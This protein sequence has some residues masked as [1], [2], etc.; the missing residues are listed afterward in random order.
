MRA[1]RYLWCALFCLNVVQGSEAQAQTSNRGDA[2]YL[3]GATFLIHSDPSGATRALYQA[4]IPALKRA[5]S[6]RTEL[7]RVLSELDELGQA[8]RGIKTP[9]DLRQL[10]DHPLAKKYNLNRFV[11]TWDPLQQRVLLRSAERDIEAQITR[12]EDGLSALRTSF[13]DHTLRP[14]I[15]KLNSKLLGLADSASIDAVLGH[16]ALAK[17][18]EFKRVAQRIRSDEPIEEIIRT[19]AKRV[20]ERGLEEVG[21]LRGRIEEGRKK[22]SNLSDLVNARRQLGNISLNLPHMGSSLNGASQSLSTL[23][24]LY[25]NGD[26]IRLA[27]QV[28]ETTAS[29]GRLQQAGQMLLA[30]GTGVGAFM[31]VSSVM[32]GLGG[33]G[34]SP[35]DNNAAVLAQLEKLFDY[36]QKQFEIVNAKLDRIIE[37][38][39]RI[40]GKVDRILGAIASLADDVRGI[41]RKIEILIAR[42]DAG[43]ARIA[44]TIW[45]G[46]VSGCIG[47]VENNAIKSPAQFS[48]CLGKFVALAEAAL[49]PPFVINTRTHPNWEEHLAAV[50]Q[51]NISDATELSRYA[52][53]INELASSMLGEKPIALQTANHA[54]LWKASH[55]IARLTQ[56][57][58]EY[59]N[60]S[61]VLRDQLLAIASSARTTEAQLTELVG[62][63][64]DDHRQRAIKLSAEG[65]QK[66]LGELKTDLSLMRDL[67]AETYVNDL[68]AV[69]KNE[70]ADQ[71]RPW[72]A[73]VSKYDPVLRD[74]AACDLKNNF[75][76]H[77]WGTNFVKD[78]LHRE[79]S[80]GN[81]VNS[82]IERELQ[83]QVPEI[84]WGTINLRSISVGQFDPEPIFE[85]CIKADSTR[86]E[87]GFLCEVRATIEYR[88]NNVAI[89]TFNFGKDQGGVNCQSLTDALNKSGDVQSAFY[90]YVGLNSEDVF[91]NVRKNL[92]AR[93]KDSPSEGLRRQFY[94]YFLSYTFDDAAR[95]KAIANRLKS[96]DAM[97]GLLKGY[98]ALGLP[99]IWAAEDLV[100][101][102]LDGDEATGLVTSQSF[103]AMR[104]CGSEKVCPD[105][106]RAKAYQ[107]RAPY[108]WV[109]HES[110]KLPLERF[111]GIA[112]SQYELWRKTLAEGITWPAGPS[113][114]HPYLFSSIAR[115]D[116]V[117]DRARQ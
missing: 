19:E 58:E 82:G 87:G 102:F 31:A 104:V 3:A 92:V 44:D 112:D 5:A 27:N 107:A 32:A 91:A 10:I 80:I 59:L 22:L 111:D 43:E 25:G 84:Q 71:L 56:E 78:R 41:D 98:F 75:G 14:A 12:S 15:L 62:K 106:S 50:V 109:S 18:E 77:R 38:V 17:S 90:H 1:A 35:S 70:Q 93:I 30:A 4:A 24:A 40:E 95:S 23:A 66:V 99:S 61:K 94:D 11:E 85:I 51:D 103:Y 53:M 115:L 86:S 72:L 21:T 6:S 114:Y 46:Q 29:I 8:V 97:V 33:L 100:K 42:L 34:S 89:K 69:S 81:N 110:K 20:I 48:D 49:Q 45:R 88:S 9:G 57:N 76:S 28:S 36:L 2:I 73:K 117:A 74:L 16:S 54:L 105:R 55:Y 63:S 83:I 60:P 67:A 108:W 26:L 52:P 39:D 113:A 79:F 116:S 64:A 65:Y 47:Q 37:T 96:L 101:L 68:V 7:D 13:E